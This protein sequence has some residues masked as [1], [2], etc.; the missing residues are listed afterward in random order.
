MRTSLSNEDKLILQ[1]LREDR[2]AAIQRIYSCYGNDLFLIANSILRDTQDA[3]ECVNDVLMCLWSKELPYEIKSLTAYLAKM[4]RNQAI[5]CLRRRERQKRGGDV[6]IVS[7]DEL[8]ECIPD[9][10]NGIDELSQ[11][12]LAVRINMFVR[13]LSK[14]DRLVFMGKY[15][16]S[17]SISEIAIQIGR[18]EGF[19]TKRLMLL[20]ERLK[21]R[22]ERG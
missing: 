4:V 9:P 21:R 7:Y 20:R 2:E 17:Q 10:R 12:E 5:M 19:V 3:E 1:M 11:D 16:L 18:S 14:T 15:W 22:L 8:S 13:E 6:S